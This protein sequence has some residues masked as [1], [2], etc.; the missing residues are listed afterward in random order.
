MTLENLRLATELKEEI[1]ALE[2]AIQ[3]IDMGELK[4]L[5]YS[6]IIEKY[7]E[8]SIRTEACRMLR[9]DLNINLM[10]LKDEFNSL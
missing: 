2:K 4:F 7:T 1:F 3:T 5:P 6:S 10:R 8:E 9:T